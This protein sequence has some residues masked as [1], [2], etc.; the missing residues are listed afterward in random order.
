MKKITLLFSLNI[1]LV[2]SSFAIDLSCPPES[3]VK[4]VKLI[5]AIPHPF[6]PDV[7]NFASTVITDRGNEWNIW[8]GT[9]LPGVR[10]K[11]EALKQ[12]QLYFNHAS[13]VIKQ[14]HAYDTPDKKWLC[15]YVPP[16]REYWISS[17]SPP[18]YETNTS[19]AAKK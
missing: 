3:A 12:G 9:F 7:W 2:S 16:G 14:P 13:I 17:M 1:L 5:K 6:D 19:R 4:S 11:E 8:F 18:G 15:D 10:T